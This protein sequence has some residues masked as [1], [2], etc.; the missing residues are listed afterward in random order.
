MPRKQARL[1]WPDDLLDRKIVS[2]VVPARE[3]HVLSVLAARN[4]NEYTGVPFQQ[5]VCGLCQVERLT[6]GGGICCNGKDGMS[7]LSRKTIDEQLWVAIAMEQAD[8]VCERLVAFFCQ[9]IHA[10]PAEL[11]N[12][13]EQ[14][15][16]AWICGG[17]ARHLK[18]PNVRHERRTQA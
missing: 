4:R 17:S 15:L 6:A 1:R 3:P 9:N 2:F 5:F 10:M 7:Y 11:A 16:L 12:V 14:L 13:I 18:A 8:G